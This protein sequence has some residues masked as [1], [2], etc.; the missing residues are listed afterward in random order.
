LPVLELSSARR[1]E[2]ASGARHFLH[3]PRLAAKEQQGV[4]RSQTSLH[5]FLRC[6]RHIPA[7]LARRPHM[8]Q[9]CSRVCGAGGRPSVSP[10]CGHGG[11]RRFFFVSIWRADSTWLYSREYPLL[12]R[13]K[14]TQKMTCF[15]DLGGHG[16][17]GHRWN[18]R[19]TTEVHV[20]GARRAY[21]VGK[22]R[23]YVRKH[24][25]HGPT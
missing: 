3:W 1:R 10:A 13:P 24:V 15:A 25:R 23:V 4:D 21:K 9:Q 22:S 11:S 8:R 19:T 16:H 7:C 5:G 14:R 2:S 18:R 12:D 20:G 6:R 17:D